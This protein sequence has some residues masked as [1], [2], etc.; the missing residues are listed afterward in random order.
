M[1]YAIHPVWSTTNQPQ[2]MRYGLYKISPDGE[3]EIA[4]AARLE[5]VEALR[6]HL[7]HPQHTTK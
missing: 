1:T 6:Q 3:Q 5:S 4:Q 2:S 7:L